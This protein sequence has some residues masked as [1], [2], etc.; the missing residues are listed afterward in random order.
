MI[1]LP[2]P[3]KE[4]S[5]N[6]RVHFHDKAKAT[7]VYRDGAYWLTKTAYSRGELMLSELPA[8]G[9]VILRCEF[10]PPDKRRRD[11]DGMFSSIKA[12]LDGIADSLEVNDHRFG[13]QIHRREPCK[14][15][16]VVV[17]IVA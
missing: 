16:R 4:L 11:L 9:E 15:G 17:S 13:F 3:P 5:P 8:E 7:K 6:A 2:W 10:H 1:E 12:G 14:G